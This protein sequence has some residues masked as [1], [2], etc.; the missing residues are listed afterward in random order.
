[1]NC[2]R[3]R[4][5]ILLSCT[6]LALLLAGCS[7]SSTPNSTEDSAS[8]DSASSGSAESSGD[9]SFSYDEM[10]TGR[11]L[12]GEYDAQEAISIQLSDDGSTCSSSFVSIDN[13]IITITG[14]GTY[15][16]LGTLTEGQVI[17][18]ADDAK[19]QLVF[20]NTNITCASSAALYIRSAD[21]VFLTLADGSDNTLSTTDEFVAID[22]N[23]ID[24]AIF[25]K[26]DLVLNGSGTLTVTCDYGHG[27]VSKDDLK[28]TGGTYEITAAGHAL[29]G[30]DSVRIADGTFHLVSEKDGIH[31]ANDD[32]TSLGYIYL[33]GGTMEIAAADDGIHAD[34]MLFIDG[35][36]IHIT[37]SYEG[38]EGSAITINDGSAVIVASDDGLNAAGNTLTNDITINGGTLC[39]DADGDGIDANRNLT[40]NGGQIYVSGPTSSADSALDFDGTGTITGGTV[41]A[42]GAGQM[43]QNFGDT[44]TQ[45]SMLVNLSAST[46]ETLV[47]TD[48]DSNEIVSFSPDKSYNSVVISSPSIAVGENY[49]LTCGSQS[50]TIE[51]S[52]LIYGKGQ[53]MGGGMK[54]GGGM[55]PGM[56]DNTDGSRPD[57]MTGERPQMPDDTTGERPQ[58]PDNT[59]G[60]KPQIPD[61]T[62]GKRPQM[63]NDTMGEPPTNMPNDNEGNTL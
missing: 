7:G 16:L 41:V 4:L 49:T 18:D 24:A 63:P 3:K 50:T 52:S 2:R 31:S 8:S 19:V 47:L 44:S 39:I 34:Q 55:K 38:L 32:D 46:S 29:C 51:M 23:N 27:I 36:E 25:S 58:M 22:D 62:M 15:L 21:K 53:Q 6:T 13:N 10:F 37:Q 33:A 26:D 17:V 57:D 59:M 1:M 56:R 35:G 48:A 40:V 12:S 20:D 9:N 42:C 5:S 54:G 45:A 14:E 28:A 43:A 60:E 61:D 30:K 11:D